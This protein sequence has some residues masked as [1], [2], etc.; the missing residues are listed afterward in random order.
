MTT[1][2]ALL[3]EGF[4]AQT[5]EYTFLCIDPDGIITAWLGAAEEMFGYREDEIV[6][7]PSALLFTPE[8]SAKGFHKNE[9]A[10]A[11]KDTRAE[12]DRW[13]VRKDGTRIWISG[14]VQAVHDSTGR[15]VGFVKLMRD[16]TD[17]RAHVNNVENEL[18]ARNAALERTHAFLSKLGHEIRN[19]LAPLRTAAEIIK[20]THTDERTIKALQIVLDQVDALTRMADDLMEAARLASHTVSLNL[21]VV[22]L[23]DVVQ[24]ACRGFGPIAESS[25]I[26][27]QAFLPEGNLPVQLDK[28]RFQQAISNLLSNAI[29]YT[30]PGGHI[31][32]KPTQ[33]GRQVVVRIEDTG[34]GIAPDMLPRLF[35]LFS[36]A[37]AAREVAPS[38]MGIGLAVVREVVEL[39]GGTVQARSPGVG[40]GSEFTIRLP[41]MQT[42]EF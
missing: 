41:A 38:G 7:K 16:R 9:L 5:R 19:P 10:I 26:D 3:I 20:K 1:S 18:T 31:W 15:V 30:K 34:I 4:L 17:L 24:D 6:G 8:D 28:P 33:E 35:E 13:H 12:D 22:D 40:K 11:A 42:D 21:Q 37:N 36:R 32:I 27:L 25:G 2:P 29:K 39:H 23:R 14:T